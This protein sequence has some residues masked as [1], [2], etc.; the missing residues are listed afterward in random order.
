M[1]ILDTNVLSALM[2]SAPNKAVLAWLNKQPRTSIWTTSVTLMEIQFGL[3]IMPTGKRR[4]FLTQEFKGVL[5]DLGGRVATFDTT[6]AEFAAE[7][8][9]TRQKKGKPVELRDTMIAGIVLANHASLA[10][11]NTNHFSDISTPVVNPW[12]SGVQQ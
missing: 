9:A 12:A 2:R 4:S 1:I 5:D 7:L 11:R 10:T 3:E 8:M 6:A